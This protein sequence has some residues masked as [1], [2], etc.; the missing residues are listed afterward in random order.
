VLSIFFSTDLETERCVLSAAICV[1]EHALKDHFDFSLEENEAK[2]S[3]KA[4]GKKKGIDIIK[5]D[6]YLLNL[7]NYCWFLIWFFPLNNRL[8]WVFLIGL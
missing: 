6:N 3:D 4:V 1:Y 8:P 7:R 2:L 5:Y